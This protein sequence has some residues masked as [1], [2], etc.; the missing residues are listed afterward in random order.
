M[1]I[2]IAALLIITLC[3][4]SAVAEAQAAPDHMTISGK[5]WMV[6]NG[7]DTSAITVTVYDAGGNP[8][9]AA[10]VTFGVA[11]PWAL[12]TTT[13]VTDTFGTVMTVL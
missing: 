8:V 2:F 3:T 5:T 13:A 12:S 6:A 10:T 9:P 7:A 1:R 4:F 11:T